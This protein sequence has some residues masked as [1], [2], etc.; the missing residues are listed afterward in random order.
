LRGGDG[1]NMYMVI[2]RGREF[3]KVRGD[4]NRRCWE[5]GY[6]SPNIK[7]TVQIEAVGIGD[8]VDMAFYSCRD[9]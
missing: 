1:K 8:S 6:V 4:G 5:A 3:F 7:D 9:L 2:D